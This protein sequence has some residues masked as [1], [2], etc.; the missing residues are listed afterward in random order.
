M[1]FQI[2]FQGKRRI[3]SG[4]HEKCSKSESRLRD[5]GEH[6]ILK[7]IVPEALW[8]LERSSPEYFKDTSLY[9]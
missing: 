7:G 4:T 5:F 3:P 8:K 1:I 6:R 9:P 2:N